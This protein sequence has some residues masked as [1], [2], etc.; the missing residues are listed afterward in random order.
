MNRVVHFEFTA[1]DPEASGRFYS[2]VF[3]WKINKWEGPIDYWLV[4]TGEEGQPG[5]NG[6]I[7]AAQEDQPPTTVT[8][9]VESVDEMT[10]KVVAAGGQVV[11]PKMPVPGVGWMAYVTDP[12]GVLFSLMQMDENAK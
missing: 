1:A 8:V 10:A 7:M 12:G 4:E 6:G 3:G 11:A 5:I 2:E 9:D